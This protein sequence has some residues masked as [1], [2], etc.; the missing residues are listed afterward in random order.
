MHKRLNVLASCVSIVVL[1]SCARATDKTLSPPSDTQWVNV[2]VQNPSPYTKPFP[3]EVRY[4]SHKCM[5]KRISGVDGSVITE[6]SYNVIKIPVQQGDNDLW[7]AKIAMTGGGSCNWT[8]SA[9]NLGIEYIDATHLGKDLVTGTAVGA[10]IAFDD[11]ASR[12]GQ[13]SSVYGNLNLSPKYFPYIRERKL[14]KKENSLSLLGKEN[15]I[16]LRAFNLSEIIFKPQLDESKV[17]KFIGL[18]KKTKGSYPKIVYPN[19][20]TAPERTLFPNF[21]LVD[22][23]KVK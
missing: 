23:M 6:P 12:N 2:E 4:I 15:F 22:K 8:L 14:G 3:L 9:F 1:S 21:D 5:K 19:G 20:T 7:K 17:V 10:T 13:F 16:S 11:D 18:E